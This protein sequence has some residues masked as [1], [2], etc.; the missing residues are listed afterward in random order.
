MS[1]NEAK[2]CDRENGALLIGICMAL[3][4]GVGVAFGSALTILGV[5]L[6]L[7]IGGGAGVGAAIGGV[8]YTTP[9]RR[10]SETVEQS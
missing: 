7:A 10:R 3:G 5:S 8:V 6:A 2:T 1:V 9:A 4:V